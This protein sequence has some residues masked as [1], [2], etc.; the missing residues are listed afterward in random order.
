MAAFASGLPGVCSAQ[1]FA[2]VAS[3]SVSRAAGCTARGTALS[4]SSPSE[5]TG[6]V[7]IRPSFAF[8]APRRLLFQARTPRAASNTHEITMMG[9][10]RRRRS[11]RLQDMDEPQ[12]APAAAEEVPAAAAEAPAEPQP[13]AV[14]REAEPEP[15]VAQTSAA[16]KRAEPIVA[17]DDEEDETPA[18]VPTPAEDQQSS[19]SGSVV[20]S[21]NADVDLQKLLPRPGEKDEKFNVWLPNELQAVKW[22]TPRQLFKRAQESFLLIFFMIMLITMTDAFFKGLAQD[23]FGH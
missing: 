23:I 13:V 4:A 14:Q 22:A 3:T 20:R 9:R 21:R 5:R 11:E 2:P 16:R 12:E 7:T 8:L 6:D 1:R 15:V 18:P 10:V 17:D 19:F